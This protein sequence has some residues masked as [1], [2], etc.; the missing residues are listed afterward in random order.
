MGLRHLSFRARLRLFFLVIVVVPMITMAVVLYQLIVA[1]EKSQTDARL[2]ESQTV[3]TGVYQES[4]AE[5]VQVAQDIGQDQQLADA[6]AADDKKAVQDRLDTLTRRAGAQYVELKVDG[7]G[8]YTSGETPAVASATRRLLDQDTQPDRADHG[9]DARTEGVRPADRDPDRPR[10]WSS[11]RTATSL[12]RPSPTPR[13]STC[14]IAAPPRS[15]ASTTASP[16]STP[17][18]STARSRSPC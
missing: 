14:P 6:L 3:A 8:T 12:R 18:P 15:R 5:A 9:R 13:G 11:G 2:A 16:R 7:K 4:T 10:R 1:S 17:T